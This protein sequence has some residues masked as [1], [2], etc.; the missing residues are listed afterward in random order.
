MDYFDVYK[1][2][3]NRYGNNFQTRIQNQREKDFENYLLKTVYRVDFEYKDEIHPAALERKSQDH[4]KTIQY[5]LT[6]IDADRLYLPAVNFKPFVEEL[7]REDRENIIWVEK[8]M[9]LQDAGVSISLFPS[10][11]IKENAETSMGIL[12][13]IENYDILMTGDMDTSGEKALLERTSL[14]KLELLMIG[15]H[16]SNT[17]TSWELLEAT[18]PKVAVISVSKDN[19]YGHPNKYVL[20]KLKIFGCKV[21]RTDRQGTIIFRG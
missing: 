6:R 21:Y 9:V 8:D 1:K 5:L 18:T 12:F 17:S 13:Q 10:E 4:T 3:L 14:P 16:G 20:N 15:H 11:N 7:S 2:R 19:H